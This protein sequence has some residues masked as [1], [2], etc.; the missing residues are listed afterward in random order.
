MSLVKTHYPPRE[1]TTRTFDSHVIRSCSLK[2]RQICVPAGFKNDFFAGL[3]LFWLL[4]R[5]IQ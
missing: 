5:F 3:I 4:F 1:T 2:L